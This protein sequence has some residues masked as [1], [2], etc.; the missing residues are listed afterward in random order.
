MSVIAS[1]KQVV[2]CRFDVIADG[3]NRAVA[4]NEVAGKG[5][6]AA[7]C[8]VVRVTSAIPLQLMIAVAKTNDVP[9]VALKHGTAIAGG[10]SSSIPVGIDV[11]FAD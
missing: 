5:M 4:E 8:P 9:V 3:M 6:G 7:E 2:N 11:F 1:G 10:D